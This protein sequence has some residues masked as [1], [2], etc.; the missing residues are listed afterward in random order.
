MEHYRGL[1]EEKTIIALAFLD[2]YVVEDKVEEVFFDALSVLLNQARE[3]CVLRLQAK[4]QTQNLDEQE[5][6]LL[7][8]MLLGK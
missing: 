4:A 3:A 6:A 8:A 2:V 1:P 7:I 5:Q